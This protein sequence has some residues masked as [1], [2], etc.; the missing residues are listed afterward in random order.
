VTL[1]VQHVLKLHFTK[2]PQG[3]SR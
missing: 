1:S 3:Y 2:N